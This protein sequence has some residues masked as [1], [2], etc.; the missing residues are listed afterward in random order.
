VL[1]VR[2]L[3][4]LRLQVDGED[5]PAPA[6]RPVRALLAW[7]ALHPGRHSRAD[8][9]A[10]LWPDVLD[11]SARASLRTALSTLRASVGDGLAADRDAVG[12]RDAWVDALEFAALAEAGRHEAAMSLGDADLLPGLQDEWALLAREEHRE[13]RGEALGALAASA[14]ERGEHEDAVRLARRRTALDPFDEP[15]HRELMGHL[16]AAGD[17]AGALAESERLAERLRRELAVAPSAATRDLVARIR[18]EHRARVGGRDV[19]GAEVSG[20]GGAEAPGVRGLLRPAGGRPPFP[21]LLAPAR[22]AG[23]FVGRAGALEQLRGLWGEVRDG[24]RR[25]ALVVGP[26]GIGKTR[27]IAA[28]AS[29]VHAGGGAVLAGV[30]DE[31]AAEP[32]SPVLG[33]LA[34]AGR[35]L[36]ASADVAADAGA[37]RLARLDGLAEALE[38]AAG[39]A[40][41][42]LVLDDVH[43]ADEQTLRLLVRIARMGSG[44]LLVLATSRLAAPSGVR[45]A[46]DEL[47]RAVPLA[48]VELGGLERSD[49]AALAHDRGVAADVDDLLARTAGTPFFV[50][51]LLA[52]GGER[53]PARVIDAVAAR[54]ARLGAEPLAVLRAAALLG[55]TIDAELAA[56]VAGVDALAALDAVEA[57]HGA[58]L[59][60]ASGVAGSGVPGADA[61]TFAHA[62]VQDALLDGLAA[63]ERARLHARAAEVLGRR[64]EAGDSASLS[65]AARHALAGSPPLP[66]TE[67]IALVTRAAAIL[68][69]PAPAS[70]AELLERALGRAT[71]TGQ[72]AL[73]DELRCRLGEALAAADR[74]DDARTAFEAAAAGARARGD[75]ELLARTALGAAGPGVTILRVDPNRVAALEEALTG[76]AREPSALRARLQARLA[77]ELAYA[78]DPRRRDELSARALDDAHALD[79]HRAVAAALGARHVVLWGPEHTRERLALADEMVVRARRAGDPALELQARTWR[80]VDLTEL[81]DGAAVDA[82]LDAYAEV[83]ARSGLA[84]YGWYVPAWR[85]TRATMAGRWDEADQLFDRAVALGERAGDGNAGLVSRLS[86]FQR[87]IAEE[88]WE[89]VPL[90][91]I[92]ERVRTSPAGWAYRQS[93]IWVLAALG[94]EDEA[95]AELAVVRAEGGPWRWPRDTNWISALQELS[96]AAWLLRDRE[97]GAE[98]HALAAP[99]ADRIVSSTR[100]LHVIGT[101]SGVLARLEDLLGDRAAAAAHYEDSI[102]R[103]ERAGAHIWAQRDR[104]RLDELLRSADRLTPA[105]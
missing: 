97:L 38:R 89:D 75:A 92:A 9:A 26:P 67:A 42:L 69:A 55:R 64:A 24:A 52:A 66:A 90:D 37:V 98:L 14:A 61:A 27:L 76:L 20:V 10:A 54:A 44:P 85:A 91:Y 31:E 30:A 50:E 3:G 21:P 82:E 68:L 8:A 86:S 72:A 1:R 103:S 12:L 7:L 100:A 18:V 36:P 102:A 45:A 2:L 13:R 80:I 93:Y 5:V 79:D 99:L 104:R 62:L 47:G 83:A 22:F 51:A 58:G 65:A 78:P 87:S 63:S 16:V 105:R 6:G 25:A 73:A 29:E 41:L 39:G 59:V 60:A 40:S 23:G 94:R 4:E 33:A 34:A 96:E 17:V 101:V 15:A 95:R 28:F 19:G 77:I 74:P 88:A 11:R 53:T 84:V 56:E 35:A 81:G 46:L 70:A 71:T 57:A 49:V 32:L 48:R 43:W